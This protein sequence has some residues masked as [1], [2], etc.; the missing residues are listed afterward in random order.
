[1]RIDIDDR[2]AAW[3]SD[4]RTREILADHII[5]EENLVTC[6]ECTELFD[7]PD[8]LDENGSCGCDKEAD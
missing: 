8:D 7:S 1:M 2:I 5:D 6:S 4:G 3:E